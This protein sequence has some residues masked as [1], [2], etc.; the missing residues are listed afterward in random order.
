MHYVEVHV[1]AGLG[2][3]ALAVSPKED[4]LIIAG[5][6]RRSGKVT[7]GLFEVKLPQGQTTFLLNGPSCTPPQSWG[8]LSLSPDGNRVLARSRNSLDLIDLHNGSI[9]ALSD[10]AYASWSPDGKWIALEDEHGVS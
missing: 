10:R 6:L 8:E 4:R 5:V 2:I 9:R 7:C 3:A 1:E